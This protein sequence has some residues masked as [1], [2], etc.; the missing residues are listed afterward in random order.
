M[1]LEFHK[2]MQKVHSMAAGMAKGEEERSRLAAKARQLLESHSG[3]LELLKARAEEAGQNW[4]WRGASPHHEP[5]AQAHALPAGTQKATIIAVDGSQIYLDR[6]AAFQ[7]YLINVGTIVF[8]QGS[9]LAPRVET[10]PS[11]FYGEKLYNEEGELIQNAEVNARRALAE[12][13]KLVAVTEEM[14]GE[15]KTAVLSLIDGPLL[16]WIL[17][18]RDSGEPN[19][20]S[21]ENYL[22][23]L[24]RMEKTGATLAG[25]VDRPNSAGVVRLLELADQD[26]AEAIKKRPFRGLTDRHL[27]ARLLEPGQR[28]SLFSSVS[29][30]NK[31]LAKDGQRISFF[32]L[33]VGTDEGAAMARVEIPQWVLDGGH[34]Q[35]DLL[36]HVLWQQSRSTQ[37]Y[38][39]VLA[40]A[41]E[42]A[43]VTGEDRRGF[44]NLIQDALLSHGLVPRQSEKSRLKALLRG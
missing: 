36:H 28:S 29:P 44:E 21:L 35:L 17:S 30:V 26:V 39:Y 8:R 27:F 43:V 15:D 34:E 41:D 3:E 18:L 23:H 20:R 24:K 25:Y 38:P 9:G 31:R 37:G 7:Y 22:G 11:I 33:N 14:A 4:K 12:I 13:E 16:L 6:H 10:E 40:R 2:L 5:L 1:T 32:Y 42:L 19:E